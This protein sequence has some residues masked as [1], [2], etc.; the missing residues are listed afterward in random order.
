[1]MNDAK[2]PT[3]EERLK[4]LMAA[5]W[6]IDIECKSSEREFAL[7]YEAH[8]VKQK[9]FHQNRQIHATGQTMAEL[10]DELENWATLIQR[11]EA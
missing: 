8:G 9:G 4:T 3:T 10:V 11:R 2:K 1:M 7:T 6:N 5:G